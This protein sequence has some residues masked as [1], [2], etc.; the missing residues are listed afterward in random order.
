MPTFASNPTSNSVA[1]DWLAF[2]WSFAI[3]DVI[4]TFD[5]IAMLRHFQ[6]VEEGQFVGIFC[7]IVDIMTTPG[8]V[9]NFNPQTTP[10]VELYTPDGA[11]LVSFTNMSNISTGVYKYLHQTLLGQQKGLYTGR[12]KAINGTMTGLSEELALFKVTE[13]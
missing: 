8:S 5:K 13:Q 9:Y 7:Y 11:M 1:F 12:F 10:Q 4:P 2:D 6:L 3:M